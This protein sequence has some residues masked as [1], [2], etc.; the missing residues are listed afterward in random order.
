MNTFSD[1]P[2]TLPVCATNTAVESGDGNAALRGKARK[3]L[4]SWTDRVAKMA[5]EGIQSR[6]IE[7]G[8]DVEKLAQH[9]PSGKETKSLCGNYKSIWTNIWSRIFARSGRRGI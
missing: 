2:T 5:A 3:A 1:S 4:R 9:Q 7:P 8:V 6:E